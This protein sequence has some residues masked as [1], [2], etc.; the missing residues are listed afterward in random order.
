MPWQASAAQLV[1]I[2]H[3]PLMRDKMVG[4]G[5]VTHGWAMG[6]QRG[7][8]HGAMTKVCRPARQ[9]TKRAD[10]QMEGGVTRRSSGGSYVLMGLAYSPSLL[11][12]VLPTWGSEGQR[13]SMAD[14][15]GSE[16]VAQ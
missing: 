13:D 3:R 4:R 15:P 16:A 10:N 8:A 2:M 5:E 7:V 6:M 1:G 14:G 9:T 12:S 11:P